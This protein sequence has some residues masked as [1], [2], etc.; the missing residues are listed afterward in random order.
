MSV[1]DHKSF[2]MEPRAVVGPS[3]KEKI[4]ILFCEEC[5]A[6]ADHF[7]PSLFEEKVIKQK[8]IVR[9]YSQINT[10]NQLQSLRREINDLKAENVRL[11]KRLEMA[12]ITIVN[13]R[14]QPTKP[15]DTSKGL[16]GLKK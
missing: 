13:M 16:V 6:I 14:K 3:G 9:Q 8:Q 2:R 15:A 4:I 7:D 1:C 5:H 10:S 11:A 12:D